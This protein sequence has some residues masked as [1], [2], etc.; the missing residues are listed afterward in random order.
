MPDIMNFLSL[1]HAI[2]SKIGLH[3]SAT[4]PDMYPPSG[5]VSAHTGP[6]LP[7]M[8]A[9]LSP[10]ASCSGIPRQNLI[11]AVPCVL[12]ASPSSPDLV[13]ANVLAHVQFPLKQL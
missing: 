3:P 8:P 10:G 13:W 9:P 11:T 2:E 6:A 7:A 12:P 5:S 1:P 4:P